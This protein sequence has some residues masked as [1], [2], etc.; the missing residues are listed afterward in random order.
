[1]RHKCVGRGCLPQPTEF[2]RSSERLDCHVHRQAAARCELLILV[3]DSFQ[4]LLQ[5]SDGVAAVQGGNPLRAKGHRAQLPHSSIREP[6]KS[7]CATISSVFK[8]KSGEQDLVQVRRKAVRS[9]SEE[10][11]SD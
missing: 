11:K 4:K 7:S 9:L 5:D 1:M 2:C 10:G 6:C 3:W 8:P